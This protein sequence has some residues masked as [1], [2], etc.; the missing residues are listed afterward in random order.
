VERAFEKKNPVARNHSLL[1]GTIN[2]TQYLPV[3][4]AEMGRRLGKY[5]VAKRNSAA[6]DAAAE[7]YLRSLP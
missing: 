7:S 4:A 5:F 6:A 1:T 3:N 2:K